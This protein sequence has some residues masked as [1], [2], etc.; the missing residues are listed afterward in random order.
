MLMFREVV[1]FDPRYLLVVLKRW[2]TVAKGLF[3]HIEKQFFG[4]GRS[5]IGPEMLMFRDKVHLDSCYLLV[6][7]KRCKPV[8]KGLF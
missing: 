7:L 6:V 3:L 8:A 5:K 4:A 2:K 1:H